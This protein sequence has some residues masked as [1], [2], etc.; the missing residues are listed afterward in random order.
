MKNFQGVSLTLIVKP[1]PPLAPNAL[2]PAL[3][4]TV[5][6]NPLLHEYPYQPQIVGKLCPL[7]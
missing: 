4:P 2:V 3:T 1:T 7:E 6:M 5:L